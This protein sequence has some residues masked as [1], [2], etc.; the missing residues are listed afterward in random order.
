MM[1]AQK[2]AAA[3]KSAPDQHLGAMHHTMETKFRTERNF[4]EFSF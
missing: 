4:C 3:M 2:N 1:E